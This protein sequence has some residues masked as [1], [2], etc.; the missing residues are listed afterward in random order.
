MEPDSYFFVRKRKDSSSPSKS[1][2]GDKSGSK[3][4]TK[5]KTGMR[6]KWR[7]V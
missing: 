3:P 5:T 4:D 2:I 7:L 1:K 6:R